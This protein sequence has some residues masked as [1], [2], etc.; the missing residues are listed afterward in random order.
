MTTVTSPVRDLAAHYQ[1]LLTCPDSWRANLDPA[2][3][4]VD[5]LAH[6]PLFHS[7]P[8][9]ILE[10]GCD[11]GNSTT[12]FLAGASSQVTSI[13]INPR[14]AENFPDC[15]KWRFIHGDSQTYET[16]NKVS[17]QTYDV[18]YIDGDHSY[19]SAYHDIE[20]YSQLVKHRGLILVH[21]VLAHD[22]FPGVWKAFRDFRYGGQPV[23]KYILPGSYGL[24]VIEL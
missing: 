5:T 24:G 17:N 12:A 9:R 22:N 8:G 15:A 4:V 13:D 21:D 7:L 11:V 20:I 3:P 2:L 1:F 14:C 19:S 18:L 6:L 16:Y 10:I 23:D